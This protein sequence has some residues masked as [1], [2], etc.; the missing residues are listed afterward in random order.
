M[1]DDQKTYGAGLAAS[2]RTQF[3]KL[4]GKVVGSEHVNP[5][6][7]D[8]KAVVAKV[9]AAKPDVVFYGGEYPASGPLSQQLKD[10]G[11]TVP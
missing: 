4:G 1:I 3:T 7:R 11:V 6:D 2:F 10:G 5:E 9:K 8:F